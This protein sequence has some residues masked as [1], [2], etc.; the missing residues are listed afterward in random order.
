MDKRLFAAGFAVVFLLVFSGFVSAYVDYGAMN[1]RDDVRVYTYETRPE[2]VQVLYK[3]PKDRVFFYQVGT[4]ADTYGKFDV[5]VA[6]AKYEPMEHLEQVVY[7][8]P[9]HYSGWRKMP[10]R[11][12]RDIVSCDGSYHLK[13]YWF[14][15]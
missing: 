7:Q 3:Q 10:C 8:R 6:E 14:D 15:W 9:G 5:P 11:D 4:Y 1:T 13:L 2:S 12:S